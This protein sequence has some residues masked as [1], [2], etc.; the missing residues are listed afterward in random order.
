MN[1]EMKI[2]LILTINIF[3]FSLCSTSLPYEILPVH[4]QAGIFYN[5]IGEAKISYD[6]FTLLSFTNL[7]IYY[8][9]LELIK[10]TYTKSLN[11]C[12][13]PN[14]NFTRSTRPYRFACNQRIQMLKSQISR[15]DEKFETISHLT[16][17]D[18][19]T[20]GRSKRGLIDG[21]SYAFKWLFG[22][23][24]ADDAKYYADA[25]S[26]VEKQNHDVQMLM[27]QQIHIIS[28]AISDYN[29]SVIDLK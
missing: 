28:E 18:L 17:H 9:K 29:K 2:I 13:H 23:P 12:K 10:T 27:K 15:L 3:T 20:F 11:L 8:E 25:I 4:N 26:A 22:V 21:V 14:E 6:D 16:S 19:S 5:N 7:S 24:D 1:H